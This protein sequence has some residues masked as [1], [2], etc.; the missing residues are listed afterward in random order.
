MSRLVIVDTSVFVDFF[1]GETIQLFETLLTQNRIL[2]SDYVRL[3][4]MAGVRKSEEAALR[5]ALAGLHHLRHDPEVFPTAALIL[6]RVRTQGI[7]VGGIDLLIAAQARLSG[8]P[9]FS[10]DKVFEMISKTGM[11]EVQA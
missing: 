11:I 6:R 8:H 2:L 7:T 5:H 4:L 10:R 1:R 3:E 9:V